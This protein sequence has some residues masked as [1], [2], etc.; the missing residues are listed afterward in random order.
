MKSN[1]MVSKNYLL[2]DN[3]IINSNNKDRFY[4]NTDICSDIAFIL[5]RISKYKIYL[6]EIKDEFY[7]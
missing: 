1:T 7:L 6:Y 3:K 5:E 4:F 2:H